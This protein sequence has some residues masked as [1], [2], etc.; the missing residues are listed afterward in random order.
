MLRP[1]IVGMQC[2]GNGH[3]LICLEGSVILRSPW[4]KGGAHL[5]DHNHQSRLTCVSYNI[6]GGGERGTRGTGGVDTG[7]SRETSV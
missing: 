6:D 5:N 1:G 7:I 2:F 4:G 3:T